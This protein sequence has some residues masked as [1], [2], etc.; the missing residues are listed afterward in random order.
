MQTPK[1]RKPSCSHLL[2]MYKL[3]STISRILYILS[4]SFVWIVHDVPLMRLWFVVNGNSVLQVRFSNSQEISMHFLLIP[5]QQISAKTT[6]TFNK[7]CSQRRS[8][9]RGKIITVCSSRRK[10]II[11]GTKCEKQT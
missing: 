5:V 1:W 2:K 10:K 3:L 9:K 8:R 6:T 4:L 7:M 11:V